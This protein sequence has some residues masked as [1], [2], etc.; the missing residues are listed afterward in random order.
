MKLGANKNGMKLLSAETGEM[1]MILEDT[2][3]QGVKNTARQFID[4]GQRIQVKIR[5]MVR[6]IRLGKGEE[7]KYGSVR[8]KYIYSEEP[9]R[10][11]A[12]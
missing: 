8:K 1:Y 7:V 2:F 3:F 5:I 11:T 6:E 9:D 10:E 4:N 12:K